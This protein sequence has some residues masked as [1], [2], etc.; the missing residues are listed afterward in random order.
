M[1]APQLNEDLLERCLTQIVEHP[2]TWN[3]QA[4]GQAERPKHET[5]C[6]TTHCLAGWA[7]V[8]S[9]EYATEVDYAGGAYYTDADGERFGLYFVETET[10]K[11]IPENDTVFIDAGQ[12]LLGL[13]RPVARRLF[14]DT[15][16]MRDPLEFAE[17]VRRT[18]KENAE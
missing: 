5:E 10:G 16:Y 3:Q 12:R 13:E 1:T 18:I 15:V 7:M 17:H 8:L 14:L 9:G 4:W 2:E 11:R 6:G